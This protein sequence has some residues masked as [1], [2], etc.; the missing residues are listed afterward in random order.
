MEESTWH[1]Q[2]AQPDASCA[3]LG[4]PPD[5]AHTLLLFSPG[6]SSAASRSQLNGSPVYRAHPQPSLILP[7]PSGLEKEAG[8]PLPWRTVS[9]GGTEGDKAT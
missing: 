6:G 8:A 9:P 3:C 7:H 1:L 4:T 2:E 5:T